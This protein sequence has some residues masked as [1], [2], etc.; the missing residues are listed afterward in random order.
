MRLYLVQHGL[1]NT[2]K[3][4]PS[5]P[6][7][8]QG[9]EE[10]KSVAERLAPLGLRIMVIWHSGKARARETAEILAEALA[11]ARGIMPRGDIGPSD[12]VDPVASN[13]NAEDFDAMIVGHMPF[14]DKL[15][16]LLLVNDETQPIVK[17]RNGGVVCLERDAERGWEINWI[18]T[19]ALV[20]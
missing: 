2:E 6:L 17:F 4:D 15:A 19:P 13:V 18:I 8:E 1:A 20:S 11:P 14:L 10:V 3:E 16:S 9:R 7:T 12:P 5:R